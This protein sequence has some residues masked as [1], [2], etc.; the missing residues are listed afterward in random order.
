MAKAARILDSCGQ[1][2]FPGLQRATRTRCA[3]LLPNTGVVDEAG[4]RS[5]DKPSA[6]RLMLTAGC[7]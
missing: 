1:P 6:E 7:E 3:P 4:P 5:V 2:L